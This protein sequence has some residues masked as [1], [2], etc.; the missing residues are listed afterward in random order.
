MTGISTDYNPDDFAN[1]RHIGPSKSE[2]ESMLGELGFESLD[3]L[4]DAA[5]PR[6]V[7]R[8]PSPDWGDPLTER[9]VLERLREVAAKNKVYRSLIGMGYYGTSIPPVVQRN[10]LENPAWY[11]AYTPYQPE[12]SQGR[13]E[14]LL[15][16]QTMISDLTGL[17]IANASLLDEATACAEAM[18]MAFR[19]TR[20]KT[21]SF[22]V[23]QSCHPQNI[24]VLRTRA[25]PLGID[26]KV[27]DASEEI[28]SQNVFSALFQYPDTYGKVRDRRE[29]IA[30]LHDNGATAI[31]SAD[32]LA[33]S[34]LMEPGAFGADIAVG[35]TQRFGLP[36]GFGG[37]HAG[38]IACEKNYWRQMPGRIVGVSVDTRGNRA[39]RLA[40]QTR[41]QH[42][43]REKATSNICTAQVLPAVL[44]SMYAVYH[45]P[46][47]IR[48][49]AERVHQLARRFATALEANGIAPDHEHF[50]DTITVNVGLEQSRILANAK[51]DK[52][53]F[54]K[55]GSD[56]IGISFDE[57]SDEE[58][59]S[60]VCKAF[61][62]DCNLPLPEGRF[63]L[64]GEMLRE[65]DFLTH[66]VFNMNRCEAGATRY[67]RRLA[68]RDLALDRC[69]I[70][71]GSC[72]M[73]LNATVEMM[74]ITWPEFSGL[75]PYI[76]TDQAEGY[77]ELIEDFSSK[78]C[79]LTGFDAIS[80]QPNSGAQGEFAG[81]MAILAY[82]ESRSEKN[83]NICLIPKSA[84]GTNAAS[85]RMA[86]MSVV[87]IE[88][89]RDGTIDLAAF[90]EIAGRIGEN[91]G[92]TMITYPST[93]G[94]FEPTIM[95]IAE[96]THHNGGQVYMD[97]AN[98]NALVG[99]V[100]LGD[101]GS[102]VSHLN[103]HKTFCIPHGGGGPG[104]GPIGVKSHL[105]PFLPG[106]PVAPETARS[107]SSAAFG[108]P[109][110]LPV[111]WAYILLMGGSGLTQA[112]KIAILNANYIAHRLKEKYE[113]C[114]SGN[115][116]L[117][118]HECIVDTRRA[119]V[120]T[121]V[122]V[123]DIAKR[124]LDNGFHP[125]TMSWPVLGTLMIEPTESEYKA[126]MDR[127]CDAMLEIHDEIESIRNGKIDPED[128]P[129][130]NAPHTIEDLV[131]NWTRSY[132]RKTGCFPSGAMKDA[133][134]WPPVNRI[135]NVWGDR[136]F[137][138]SR[139]I[140]DV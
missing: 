35:T 62:A 91:L 71:L 109:S 74:P 18:A 92:A 82:H 114:Y 52:I 50:F 64:P 13:L 42:I 112:T 122:S 27:G 139:R 130:K 83:R 86:G 36:I 63:E 115:N 51:A 45:G 23:D 75:H 79:A 140:Y 131:G 96:I 93:H 47:G 8:S 78:L 84:H 94:V 1:L 107:V 24:A 103:L 21:N 118:A 10:I 126:E 6:E 95:K 11:T 124:L 2:V 128:N 88:T 54:R 39:L 5:I 127:F 102:D 100:R 65:S 67:M 53:N 113:I 20:A 106:D 133:K 108:S 134:Y 31:V 68:D 48:A 111:S 135:D 89:D 55:V 87:G 59:L 46:V 30:H 40:L 25:E 121:T 49:I 19:A 3:S 28:R 81:L 43:R 125:P 105:V 60:S 12:I 15:N 17:E 66:P 104:M 34:F 72:T 138:G 132:S 123:D 44:A 98:L 90:E 97:G 4:V 69:M 136:N 26:L 61:G 58:T 110:I 116:G 117:V 73:K 77:M 85:A 56:R 119:V 80:M 137:V 76:P 29:D 37:P 14:A 101:L 41:E 32:V 120:G 57:L 70:P 129:L 22:V 99:L 16:F 38:Y 7:K 33:L 9:Q